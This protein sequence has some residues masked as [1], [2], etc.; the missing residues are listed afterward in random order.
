MAG[1]GKHGGDRKSSDTVSLENLGIAKKQS[2]R[3]Q[4]EAQVLLRRFERQL[5]EWLAKME[6][7][8]GGRPK[9]T[10]DTVSPVST[11]DDLGIA[12]KQSSRWQQEAGVVIIKHP[13]H[14]H[15]PAFRRRA[16]FVAHSCNVCSECKKVYTTTQ[17]L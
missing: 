16:F 12:K 11:L 17:K 7:D 13:R 1:K 15:G 6:K 14:Q 3:W 8:Q 10:G 2:S 9:K 4:Q 5:G